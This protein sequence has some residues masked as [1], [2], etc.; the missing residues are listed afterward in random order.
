MFD[1]TNLEKN[2]LEML[3]NMNTGSVL[4]FSNQSFRDFIQDSAG[5]D[6]Y[7]S[8]YKYA[9]HKL[10]GNAVRFPSP[11]CTQPVLMREILDHGEDNRLF[12]VRLCSQLAAE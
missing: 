5:L 2:K 7:D 6:I 1:L 4:D 12:E 11:E 8:N 3:L 9:A 10:R